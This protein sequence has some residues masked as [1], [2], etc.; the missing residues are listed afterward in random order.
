MSKYRPF[1]TACLV[2]C[3]ALGSMAQRRAG[4]ALFTDPAGRYSIEF[5]SDWR[6][7][8]VSPSGEPL[9]T[10]VQPRSEAAVVVERFRSKQS[11]P[12]DEINLMFAQSETD[13][14]KDYQP[15]TTE[16]VAKVVT[17]GGKRIV[18]IDYTRPGVD[19]PERVRQYSFPVGQ[20]LFRVTC[21]A[22][23]DEFKRYETTFTNVAESFMPTVET[24]ASRR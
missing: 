18:V 10:F 8:I 23:A 24:P 1:V 11:M 4:Y 17:Q 13:V 3:C 14:L 21:M 16:V 20:N 7:M 6:W 22:L 19:A 2:A 15:K 9:V 12:D 5:P